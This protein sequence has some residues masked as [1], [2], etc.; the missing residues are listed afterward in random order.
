MTVRVASSSGAVDTSKVA[1]WPGPNLPPHVA[2]VFGESRMRHADRVNAL[3]YSPDGTKLASASRDGTVKLWDLGNGRDLATYRGHADQPDAAH[4]T[5]VAV[6]SGAWPRPIDATLTRPPA[7]LTGLVTDVRTGDR[8]K[9]VVVQAT[10]PSSA[11]AK[12][13]QDGR[14]TLGGGVYHALIGTGFSYAAYRDGVLSQVRERYYRIPARLP[15]G[16]CYFFER[17]FPG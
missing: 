7:P 1:E 14:Y 13:G 10:G 4:A 17:Y 6:R 5:P 11:T 2:R 8:I 15:V 9:N 16:R 12:T 3:S